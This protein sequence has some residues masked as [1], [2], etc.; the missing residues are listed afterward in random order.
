MR[1][2]VRVTAVGAGDGRGALLDGCNAEVEELGRLRCAVA[3]LIWG[4]IWGGEENV[5]R[6]YVAV[7]DAFGVG[8]A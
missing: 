7:D 6:L 3:I 4:L 5:F 1:P 2:W 8:R